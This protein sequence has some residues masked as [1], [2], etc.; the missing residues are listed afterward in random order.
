[1]KKDKQAARRP[2]SGKAK[3]LA[4]WPDCFSWSWADCWVIYRPTGFG[5]VT[6]GQGATAA[7]AW[8]DAAKH[9]HA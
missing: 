4:Q 9:A 1:M 8:K 2:E 6:I 5:N 3:I 7:S